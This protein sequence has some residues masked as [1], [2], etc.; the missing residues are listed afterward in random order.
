MDIDAEFNL[1]RQFKARAEPVLAAFEAQQGDGMGAPDGFSAA[2]WRVISPFID[3]ASTNNER[4]AGWETSDG[5]LPRPIQDMALRIIERIERIEQKLSDVERRIAEVEKVSGEVA[6][7]SRMTADLAE[8]V[9]ARA[10]ESAD[11]NP[12]A[13][14][15]PPASKEGGGTGTAPKRK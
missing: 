3:L 7:L 10:G 14:A 13:A 1:L 8:I 12:G 9:E 5:D 11:A 2:Q 4:L 6:R 15:A